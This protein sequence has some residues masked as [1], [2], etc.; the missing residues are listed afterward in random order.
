MPGIVG[1][2]PLALVDAGK[3]V[4]FAL[5]IVRDRGLLQVD[6]PGVE[7]ARALH[8]QPLPERHRQG[9]GEE[10]GD[11]RDENRLGS[12]TTAG[13]GAV[14]C[15]AA[16]A[17]FD[18]RLFAGATFWLEPCGFVG[19]AVRFDVLVAPGF[20]FCA[21]DDF[22][23]AGGFCAFGFVPVC[24]VSLG[25]GVSLPRTGTP[26]VGEATRGGTVPGSS[27]A[28]FSPRSATT[29]TVT[30]VAAAAPAANA[31]ANDQSRS[32]RVGYT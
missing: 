9:A 16:A 29:P 11:A 3:G 1:G 28:G 31:L 20:G 10:P 19:A 6:L 32:L 21:A 26:G 15:L 17:C 4:D 25:A 5:G 18:A 27:G 14:C 30:T 2:Q 23:A 7:L 22:G 8:A 24:F 12:A 13:A